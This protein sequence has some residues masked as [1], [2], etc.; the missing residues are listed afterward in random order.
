[1]ESDLICHV[2]TSQLYSS[3]FFQ[4]KINLIL[5]MRVFLP[6]YRICVMFALFCNYLAYNLLSVGFNVQEL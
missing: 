4:K 1:M 3:L 6:M 5:H 2:H